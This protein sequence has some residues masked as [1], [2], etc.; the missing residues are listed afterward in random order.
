MIHTPYQADLTEVKNYL[1]SKL[2]E[3]LLPEKYSE[4]KYMLDELSDNMQASSIFISFSKVVRIFGKSPIN[5]NSQQS[6]A[7]FAIRKNWIPPSTIDQAIRLLILLEIP[8]A[9]QE[10]YINTL[11]EIFSTGDLGELVVLYA[12]LP[13]LPYPESLIN[14]CMEGIRTNMGE[15]FESIAN[16]NPFPADYLTEDAFN[17]MVLKCLFIGKPLYRVINLHHRLNKTLARMAADYAHERW[18]A[19]RKI[20]PEL[21]Q[22][23]GPFLEKQN[24]KDVERSIWNGEE[25]ERQAAILA[26]AQSDLEEAQLILFE[27]NYKSKIDSGELNWQK[28]GVEIWNNTHL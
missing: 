12:A 13:V 28:L 17:Q 9:N 26:C 1:L 21:W 14:R 7:A 20:N 4:L 22:L 19:L 6:T 27:S 18:A 24:M 5:Y 16:N 23:I 8:H 11:E 10:I 25:H 15:V 2:S 3:V